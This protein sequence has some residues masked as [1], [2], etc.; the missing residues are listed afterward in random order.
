MFGAY[1][2]HLS[3]LD[4]KNLEIIA[5]DT[6]ETCIQCL[7]LFKR[8]LIYFNL[9]LREA[10]IIYNNWQIFQNQSLKNVTCVQAYSLYMFF[11]IIKYKHNT[12]YWQIFNNEYLDIKYIE[13]LY[14][15]ILDKKYYYLDID[16]L[17]SDIINR[18][19]LKDT[20]LKI[21]TI[22]GQLMKRDDKEISLI[23]LGDRMTSTRIK[24]DYSMN[25][26]NYI[27]YSDVEDWD[28]IKNKTALQNIQEKLEFFDFQNL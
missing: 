28:K 21:G 27:F 9:S 10:E 2:N 1:V 26:S 6:G 25:L 7:E 23:N 22:E 12:F 11:M 5:T 17:V 14:K 4:D 3:R 16:D 24:C 13:N 8:Y 18:Y 15:N 20:I 19:T